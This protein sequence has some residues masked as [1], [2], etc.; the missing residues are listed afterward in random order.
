[1]DRFSQTKG[2]VF[3][4]EGTGFL[5]SRDRL[6]HIKGWVFM[7]ICAL[8]HLLGKA[9]PLCSRLWCLTVS[10]SLSHWHPGSGVVLDCNDS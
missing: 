5:T 6:S 1:M 7:F 2:K 10:L 8:C 9:S 4:Y 3:S